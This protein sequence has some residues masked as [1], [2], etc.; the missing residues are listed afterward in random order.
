[1]NSGIVTEDTRN[2]AEE[3]RRL[4]EAAR[5]VQDQR[6]AAL[7]ASRQEREQMRQTA[8]IARTVNE[9]ARVAAEA[10][11][12]AMVD[13]IRATAESLNATLQQMKIV[14]EMRRSLRS[15]LDSHA[16]GS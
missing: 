1:M 8:E 9:N 12:A 10:E 2:E 3:L 11:R 16:T 4:A 13:A 15:T 5:E 7:E 6:R 14:E